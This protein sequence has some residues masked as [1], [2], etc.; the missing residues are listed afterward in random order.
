MFYLHFCG[1]LSCGHKATVPVTL[2]LP[3]IPDTKKTVNQVR[4]NHSDFRHSNNFLR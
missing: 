1:I 4:P 3:D 2:C